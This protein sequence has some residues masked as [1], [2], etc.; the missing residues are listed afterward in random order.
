MEWLECDR[1]LWCAVI[2]QAFLDI[3][4]VSHYAGR[5]CHR[6]I[7]AERALEWLCSDREDLG[8]FNWICEGLKLNSSFLRNGLWQAAGRVRHQG[9]L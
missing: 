9:V 7:E 8:S 3:L 2:L 6:D 1:A 5:G 4:R